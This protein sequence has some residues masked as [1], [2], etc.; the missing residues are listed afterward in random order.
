MLVNASEKLVREKCKNK[1]T[2]QSTT[3]SEHG[4]TEKECDCMDW[5]NVLIFGV[6]PVL[7]VIIIFNVKKKLLWIA[8][9][10]STV[11]AFIT[12]MIVLAPITIVE[13]FNNNEWR[14]FFL[15]AMLIHFGIAVVHTAIAYFAA[16]KLKRKKK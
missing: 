13:L 6:I 3:T 4:G 12:Y 1:A 7:T 15:L 14:S 10:I 8:P 11:L 5:W 2:D 9:L 16:Y